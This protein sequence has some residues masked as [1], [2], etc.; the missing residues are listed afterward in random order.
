MAQV[1]AAGRDRP[2]D[3]KFALALAKAFAGEC[4]VWVACVAHR[5]GNFRS[6]AT[7]LVPRLVSFVVA[8]GI[9]FQPV[10]WPLRAGDF[11]RLYHYSLGT[12]TAVV[13]QRF[14]AA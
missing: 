6:A 9:L 5:R 1:R 12:W 8:A 10:R 14:V 3:F 11:L 4:L 13:G 7:W 2:G